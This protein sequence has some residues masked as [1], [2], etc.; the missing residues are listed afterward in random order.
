M[1]IEDAAPAVD[2]AAFARGFDQWLEPIYG[3]VARRIEDRE[4]AEAVT[5][6]TFERAAESIAKGSI[7]PEELGG[8][9]LRVAA[10]ATLDHARRERRALPTSSRAADLDEEGD[11]EAALWLADATAARTFAAAIDGIALRRAVT[12]LDDAELHLVLLR[13]LDGLDADGMAA[14]LGTPSDAASLGLHRALAIL[15][16][17]PSAERAD[18]HVA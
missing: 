11:A 7:G 2:V 4:A 1:A 10:S 14:V 16:P 17:S 8:F 12:A 13:Y 9:L 3:F 18:A 15:R 6:R 5:T